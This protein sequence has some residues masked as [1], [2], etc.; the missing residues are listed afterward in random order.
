LVI[1]ITH[2][3]DRELVK[4][5]YENK[6]TEN[7][8]RCS[9]D[10]RIVTRNGEERWIGHSCQPVYDSEGKWIGQRGSNRDITERIKTEQ[11]LMDSKIHLRELMKHIDEV[12]ELERTN[13]AREIHDELG[14][15]LTSLKFDIEGLYS[16]PHISPDE[17]KKEMVS[18]TDVVDQ[19]I[20]SVRK[21]ATDLRPGI[22]DHLGLIPAIEWQLEQFTKRTHIACEYDLS[23][24]KEAFSSKV[25]T[26]IFRIFQEILTNIARHSKANKVFV[27]VLRENGRIIFHITDNGAG[28]EFINIYKTN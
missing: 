28:F 17:L 2:P 1:K 19:L 24:L 18:I 23:T 9:I 8:D 7:A 5:H 27:S 26:V 22:L 13:M 10:F 21:I 16:N 6:L 11:V 14:H 20:K 25:T 15:L 3:D 4:T 12:T